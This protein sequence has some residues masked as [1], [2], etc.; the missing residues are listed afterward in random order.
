MILQKFKQ[1]LFLMYKALKVCRIR[2]CAFFATWKFL[3]VCPTGMLSV[4]HIWK[5]IADYIISFHFSLTW[6]KAWV[7]K[8]NLLSFCACQNLYT[9]YESSLRLFCFHLWTWLPNNA[10]FSLNEQNFAIHSFHINLENCN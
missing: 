10:I 4:W 2:H 8:N 1:V 7:L 9:W 3:Q 5:T 6:T